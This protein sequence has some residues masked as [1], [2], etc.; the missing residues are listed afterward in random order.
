MIE[1]PILAKDFSA[2]DI[3]GKTF[4]LS[5]FKGNKIL[6]SFYRNGSCVFGNLRIHELIQEHGKWLATGL[7]MIA[8][9]ES[10]AAD[11]HPY[12][13]KHPFPI[14]I[15]PDPAAKLYDLYDVENSP[16][17]INN[18]IEKNIVAERLELATREG[19]IRSYQAN[20]NLMRMPADFLID[21]NFIVQKWHYSNFLIDQLSI[22][23][24]FVF[25]K[26]HL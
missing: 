14:T 17:K 10:S 21:E 18:I 9:F 24:I 15:L 5:D 19:F 12:V 1:R 6:L 7:K 13:K 25:A 20:S 16:Q 22:Q 26:N 2:I 8:V 3:N 11:I 23:E 4:Q